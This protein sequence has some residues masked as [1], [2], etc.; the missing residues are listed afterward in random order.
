M[1]CD[2][3]NGSST[4]LSPQGLMATHI[5]EWPPSLVKLHARS[6]SEKVK[7]PQQRPRTYDSAMQKCIY[8]YI[9]VCVKSDKPTHP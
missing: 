9:Y 8:I 2:C 6:G 1:S 3:W 7:P 5:T 4:C